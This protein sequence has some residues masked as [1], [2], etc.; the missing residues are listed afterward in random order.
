MGLGPLGVGLLD[1][2]GRAFEPSLEWIDAEQAR[3]T[4]TRLMARIAHASKKPAKPLAPVEQVDQKLLGKR[5]WRW[6]GEPIPSKDLAPGLLYTSDTL[7][8]QGFKLPT[9]TK[10]KKKG[11][12]NGQRTT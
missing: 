4:H 3:R 2:L 10:T 1:R 5:V 7:R 8:A 12:K 9:L 6:I 11:K